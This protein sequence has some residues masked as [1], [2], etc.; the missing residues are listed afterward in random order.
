M[1]IK[2]LKTNL[3]DFFNKIGELDKENNE[4]LE[5]LQYLSTLAGLP[6]YCSWSGCYE[7]LKNNQT[8]LYDGTSATIGIRARQLYEDH[9]YIN[10]QIEM[11]HKIGKIMANA[12]FWKK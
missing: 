4:I 5:K 12:E 7:Q 3:Q 1:K 2:Q 11:V 8:A 9:C 6:A 10:G